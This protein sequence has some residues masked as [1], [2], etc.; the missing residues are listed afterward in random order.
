MCKVED[1]IMKNILVVLILI[2]FIGYMGHEVWVND[3]GGQEYQNQAK[4]DKEKAAEKTRKKE[5]ELKKQQK[6]QEVDIETIEALD[7]VMQS[8]QSEQAKMEA[9]NSAV[10]NGV[11]PQSAN[12]QSAVSA[13][14]ES[15]QMQNQNQNQV[16]DQNTYQTPD[17][18]TQVNNGQEQDQSQNQAQDD[19]QVQNQVNE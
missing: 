11:I 17:S 12:Y 16:Q 4:K 10:K 5:A 9:Y 8:N 19:S 18:D 2:A 14:Q 13:Y 6:A 3:D 1:A 7:K 15:L